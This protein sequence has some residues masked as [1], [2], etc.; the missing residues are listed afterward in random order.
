MGTWC[1]CTKRAPHDPPL[2]VPEPE[3]PSPLTLPLPDSA[4]FKPVPPCPGRMTK[5]HYELD[6]VMEPRTPF[7]PEDEMVAGSSVT[8]LKMQRRAA[9][10]KMLPDDD[11]GN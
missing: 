1:C 3:T 4:E 7:T 9:A 5:H 10:M 2:P 11:F 8:A 6:G